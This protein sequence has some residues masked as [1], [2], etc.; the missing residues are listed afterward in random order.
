MRIRVSDYIGNYEYTQAYKQLSL[1][2]CVCVYRHIGASHVTKFQVQARQT[3]SQKNDESKHRL[4]P[5]TLQL[6][7][8]HPYLMR[9]RANTCVTTGDIGITQL[10]TQAKHKT[11]TKNREK[12][13]ANSCQGQLQPEAIKFVYVYVCVVACMCLCV[14]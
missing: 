9:P 4:P 1:C 11:H 13:K 3:A 5:P 2:V 7:S 8:R 12:T 14:V 6:G 10:K